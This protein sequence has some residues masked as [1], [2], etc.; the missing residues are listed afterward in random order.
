MT[1]LTKPAL[2]AKPYLKPID[3]EG[4]MADALDGLRAEGNYRHFVRLERIAGRFPHALWHSETG[5]QEIIVWCANDYLGMAQHPDV[6]KAL[7]D[8]A[9]KYG[10]GAGGTRN[11]SGTQD[12]HT[13]L[14]KELAVLH[15]KESA[16]L[17]TS[18]FVANEAILSTVA[19]R[20]PGCVVL[21]D[22]KNHA[23]MIAGMRNAR[24]EKRIFPHND[25]DALRRS[26]KDLDLNRPKLIAVESVYSM[27]GT[28]ADLPAI[29]DLAKTHNALTYVDEV[30]AV[31]LYGA[32]GAGIAEQEGVAQD[33]DIIQGTLAKGFGVMGGYMAASRTLVDFVRSFAPGFIFT[34][35]LSP[36]LAEAALASVRHVRQAAGLRKTHQARAASLKEKLTSAGIPV[37]PSQT[38]I[39]PVVIGDPV[40]TKA[41]SDGLLR[42]HGLYAQPINYPTVPKGTERLRLTPSPRH[43]EAMI[44]QLVA[45]LREEMDRHD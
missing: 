36:V 10:A 20:L 6:I 45:A 16:L 24:V 38:Q 26:L 18:G 12:V 23:S 31:G 7:K 28:A 33:I 40:K 19:G 2:A 43:S 25:V 42:R 34:T 11:I 15:G 30:H 44:D 13:R 27:D 3:Y 37:M 32:T 17:F 8:A 14:E 22:E 41:I 35:A 9:E 4:F 1:I 29:V 21:S 5:P 39:V